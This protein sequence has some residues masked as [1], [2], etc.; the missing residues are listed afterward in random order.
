LRD[1]TKSFLSGRYRWS[2]HREKDQ[3]KQNEANK[4]SKRKKGT[5]SFLSFKK[6]K[7]KKKENSW[8][9]GYRPLNLNINVFHLEILN[10]LL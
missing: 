10:P 6:K 9:I 8:S 7:K 1:Y 4:K 5:F 3:V 2:I